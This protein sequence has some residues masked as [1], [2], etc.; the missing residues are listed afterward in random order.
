MSSGSSPGTS[1]VTKEAKGSVYVTSR[2]VDDKFVIRIIDENACL[3]E[4]HSTVEP[5]MRGDARFP[6]DPLR[7]SRKITNERT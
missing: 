1:S 6:G 4:V 3:I 7:P 2:L 5:I